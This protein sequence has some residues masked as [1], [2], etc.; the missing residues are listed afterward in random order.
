MLVEAVESVPVGGRAAVKAAN[1]A[2]TEAVLPKEDEAEVK[3]VLPGA[4]TCAMLSFDA[5]LPLG[6]GLL[7]RFLEL[8]LSPA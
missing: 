6:R 1:G 2:A 5:E 3:A 7:W 8:C 4:R